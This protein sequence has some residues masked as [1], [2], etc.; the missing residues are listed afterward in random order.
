MANTNASY[1]G[2]MYSINRGITNIIV[3]FKQRPSEEA[4][5][6]I[7]LA[8]KTEQ[9]TIAVNAL[10]HLWKINRETQLAEAI[11]QAHQIYTVAQ[12]IEYLPEGNKLRRNSTIKEIGKLEKNQG[13]VL[14]LRTV[15][16]FD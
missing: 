2:A 13:T 12:A 5:E 10:Q 3:E 8:A 6:A 7:I 9:K 4:G 15:N 14:V 16:I 1:E 11:G